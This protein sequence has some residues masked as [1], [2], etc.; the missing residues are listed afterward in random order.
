MTQ[1]Q[2]IISDCLKNAEINVGTRVY[3]TEN[4]PAI[5]EA[6]LCGAYGKLYLKKNPLTIPKGVF[7]NLDG[8][9]R[10][11]ITSEEISAYILRFL[12]KEAL[13]G[14]SV[15]FGG[16][17]MGYLTMEDRLSIVK[18]LYESDISPFCVIFE[19]DYITAEYTSEMLKEKTVAFYNDGPESF[20]K[21][22]TLNLEN[23]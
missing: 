7:I 2:R 20:E 11:D 15:E 16:D 14:L 8:A 6:P 23:I 9:L 5:S 18:T 19:C 10:N 17:A 21:I 22:I 1:T 12:K 4:H 3:I 13:C